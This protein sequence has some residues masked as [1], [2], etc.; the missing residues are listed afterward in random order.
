MDVR[1]PTLHIQKRN[2]FTRTHVQIMGH[3]KNISISNLMVNTFNIDIYQHYNEG[4]GPSRSL[5]CSFRDESCKSRLLY[6][7]IILGRFFFSTV[8]SPDAE[9][10]GLAKGALYNPV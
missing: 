3:C 7:S 2:Y 10:A 6:R 4:G 9:H 5:G 8:S 1:T